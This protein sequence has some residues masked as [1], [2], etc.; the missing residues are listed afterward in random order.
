[1]QTQ[2]KNNDWEN[3]K[4][5][6]FASAKKSQPN[7]ETIGLYTIWFTGSA[8]KQGFEPIELLQQYADK[9]SQ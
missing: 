3:P 4:Y 5:L 1:L 2:I 7:L 6:G 8:K 9:I